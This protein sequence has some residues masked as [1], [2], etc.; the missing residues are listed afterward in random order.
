MTTECDWDET[1]TNGAATC[2]TLTAGSYVADPPP[3]GDYFIG[4]V[5]DRGTERNIPHS[6]LL[7]DQM[8][9]EIPT[10]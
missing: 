8:F 6:V 9:I 2:T 5:G 1:D 10:V 3:V 4:T 7:T